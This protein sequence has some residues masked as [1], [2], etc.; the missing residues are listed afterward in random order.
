MSLCTPWP[1]V[2]PGLAVPCAGLP[3]G[4]SRLGCLAKLGSD[5]APTAWKGATGHWRGVATPEGAAEGTP[6][7]A[8]TH[9]FQVEQSVSGPS[10]AFLR[11]RQGP[12]AV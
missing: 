5:L 8:V 7:H 10:D 12:P 4:G 2:R 11:S 6:T 1:S 9:G 3:V